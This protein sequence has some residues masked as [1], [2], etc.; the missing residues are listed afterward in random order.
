MYD[1]ACVYYIFFT[2]FCIFYFENS[3]NKGI[4]IDL[5]FHVLLLNRTN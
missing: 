2:K 4:L 5:N 3:V 1:S